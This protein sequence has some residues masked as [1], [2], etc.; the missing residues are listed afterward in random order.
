MSMVHI[1]KTEK[2]RCS[3]ERIMGLYLA[4]NSHF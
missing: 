1:I 3:L 2:D 4:H